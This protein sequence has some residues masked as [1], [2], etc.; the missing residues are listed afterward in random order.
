[1]FVDAGII[2]PH[3]PGENEC[4]LYNHFPIVNFAPHDSVIGLI[5][6]IPSFKG[7]IMMLEPQAAPGWTTPTARAMSKAAGIGQETRLISNGSVQ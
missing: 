2:D 3:Y 1:L 5:L 4:L 6:V 7:E